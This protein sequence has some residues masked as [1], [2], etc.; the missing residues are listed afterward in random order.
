M[1]VYRLMNKDGTFAKTCNGKTVWQQ[2]GWLK[3][4]YVSGKFVNCAIVEYE[5]VPTGKVQTVRDEMGDESE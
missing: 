4:K 5:L 2:L 3:N 1:K